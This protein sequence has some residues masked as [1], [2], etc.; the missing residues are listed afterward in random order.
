VKVLI[1]DDEPS[2]RFLLRIAFEAAGHDV[3]EAADGARALE[4][5]AG[6][7]PDGIATDY[8]MPVLDGRQLIAR[9]REDPATTELPILLV[10]SSPG[11]RNVEGAD[12]FIAKPLD[13]Q[14]V[15]VELERLVDGS[16]A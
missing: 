2:I 16:A 15:V 13:P 7:H 8:M 9:L 5:V 14:D 4:A 10:S 6:E 12:H 11:A 3:V 1:V